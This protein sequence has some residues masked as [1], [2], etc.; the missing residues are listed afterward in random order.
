MGP[1]LEKII[2]LYRKFGKPVSAQEKIE[3]YI[4]LPIP[5]IGYIDILYPDSV[6]D[7]KT[8]GIMPKVRTDY[9]L[10]MSL[11]ST[12]KGV[13]PFID[14]VYVTKTKTELHTFPIENVDYHFGE[15]VRISEIMM[16]LVSLSTDIR[17]IAHL[18]C[19][20][21]DL[22]NEDFSRQWGPLEK[23]GAYE[24]FDIKRLK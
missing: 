3:L 7:I 19:L 18:S 9:N 4:G 14:A 16:R 1:V 20:T 13:P 8:T 5:L 2:P 12:A 24:I 23:Q 6:R 11:Y 21:P 10:Q 17:E 15:L 22:S